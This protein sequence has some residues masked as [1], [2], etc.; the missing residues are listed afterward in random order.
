[1][2][3]PTKPSSNSSGICLHCKL[4]FHRLAAHM[5]SSE[6]CMIAS[7]ESLSNKRVCCEYDTH[8]DSGRNKI[9]ISPKIT[10]DCNKPHTSVHD[11]Q[12]LLASNNKTILHSS[13]E[14]SDA[15]E[16]DVSDCSTHKSVFSSDSECH[17]FDNKSYS[18]NSLPLNTSIESIQVLPMD[19]DIFQ[20]ESV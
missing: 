19:S 9:S 3:Q 6:R 4:F 13:R 15:C 1:M 5:V 14:E 17:N 10:S 18:T 2:S 12:Q 7:Q 16:D 11:I 20:Q 8:V